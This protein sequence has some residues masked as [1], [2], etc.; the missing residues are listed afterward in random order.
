MGLE[1]FAPQHLVGVLHLCEQEGWSTMTDDP[2]RALRSLTA[3]GVQTA[4]AVA[5][6]GQVVGFSQTVSDGAIQAYLARLL[7]AEPH[8]RQGIGRE[9]LEESLRRSGAQRLDLIADPRSEEFFRSFPHEAWTGYRIP[10]VEAG[11]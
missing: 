11:A 2:D 6:D 3:P 9:L 7:V 5:D 1:L 10:L 4:V 8:R